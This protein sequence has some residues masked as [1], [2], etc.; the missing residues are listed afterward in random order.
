MAHLAR[1]RWTH[2]HDG[3]LTVFLIGVRINR[4]WR[5]DAWLPTLAAMPPMLAELSADADSGLLGYQMLVGGRG[6]TIIQ[7]WRRT[8]DVYRYASEPGGKHRPAWT[9]FNRRARKVSGAVGVWHE[10]YQISRAESVYVDMPLVGLAASTA[11][12]PVT[13]HLDRA[14]ARLAT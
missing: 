3:E 11:A 2:K 7:Y 6:A 14:R 10:T 8:E 1:G 12:Q 9:A 13:S 4:F 5:P